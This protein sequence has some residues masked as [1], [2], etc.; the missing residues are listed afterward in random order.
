MMYLSLFML[1]CLI[2]S[3]SLLGYQAG[4]PATT[5]LVHAVHVVLHHYNQASGAYEIK[6]VTTS[7]L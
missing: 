3:I 4:P 1:W 5:L 7:Y 6:I 2:T